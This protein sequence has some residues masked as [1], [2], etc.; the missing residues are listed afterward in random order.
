[1]DDQLVSIGEVKRDI[2]LL[3][4]RVAHGGQ[5]IVLTSRG[6]RKAAIVSIEDYERLVQE[7]A[8]R[9]QGKLE[10]WLTAADRLTA[11]IAAR[12]KGELVD[13]DALLDVEK[14]DREGRHDYLRG[15]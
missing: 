14:N 10:A 15:D 9:S 2:S 1:M 5:R 3:V 13:A 7:E 6:K 12:R 4:N 11:R 8:A